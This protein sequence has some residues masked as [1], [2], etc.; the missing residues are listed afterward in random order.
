MHRVIDKKKE[1]EREREREK[2]KRK[3][4]KLYVRHY[5]ARGRWEEE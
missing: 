1:R 5:L 2:K 4:D 3:G